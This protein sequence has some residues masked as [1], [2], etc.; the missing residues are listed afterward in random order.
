MNKDIE[1]VTLKNRI[2]ISDITKFDEV[3]IQKCGD[4]FCRL[5]L[6]CYSTCF[7]ND[8]YRDYFDFNCNEVDKAFNYYFQIKKIL[9]KKK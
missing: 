6:I 7:R 8:E 1:I 4:D 3:K 5:Y 2:Y 9:S